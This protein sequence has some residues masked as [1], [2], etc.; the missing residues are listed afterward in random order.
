MRLCT[1]DG[2]GRK[3]ESAGFCLMHY[4]RWRKH[5]DPTV[6]LRAGRPHPGLPARTCGVDDCDERHYAR[7]FC[8]NHDRKVRLYGDPLACGVMGHPKGVYRGASATYLAA[9]KRVHTDRGKASEHACSECGDRAQEWAYDHTDPDEQLS[10]RGYR[11]SLNVE[12]Y[13][14]MCAKCHR[15]FDGPKVEAN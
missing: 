12:C 9:H 2:C 11:Y 10:D 15:A 1:I 8:L 7:G 6:V 13:V 14:P 5:G 4:R 3:Y